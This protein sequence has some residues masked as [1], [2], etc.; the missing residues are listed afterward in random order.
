[1]LCCSMPNPSN[2][3]RMLTLRTCTL[4]FF[5]RLIRDGNLRECTVGSGRHMKMKDVTSGQ[6]HKCDL[7]HDREN[8]VLTWEKEMV[9]FRLS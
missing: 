5:R 4:Q 9:A 7:F 6:L 3:I 8:H 1:M 2:V